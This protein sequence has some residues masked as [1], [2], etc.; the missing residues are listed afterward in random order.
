MVDSAR[1]RPIATE[2][3]APRSESSRVESTRKKVGGRAPGTNAPG[4]ASRAAEQCAIDWDRVAGMAREVVR[5]ISGA[6]LPTSRDWELA[7]KASCLAATYGERWLWSAVNGARVK[8]RRRPWGYLWVTLLDEATRLGRPF[9]R[10]LAKIT[11]PPWVA[12]AQ[13]GEVREPRM[14]AARD[15]DD[16]FDP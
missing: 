10:D 8:A 9:R 12:L 7:V 13:P 5:R 14:C 6:K 11:I 2:S 15:A 3:V 16:E 4:S 1:V